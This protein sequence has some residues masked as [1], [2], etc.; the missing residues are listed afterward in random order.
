LIKFSP[1][2]SGQTFTMDEKDLKFVGTYN[3]HFVVRRADIETVTTSVVSAGKSQLRVIGKG[4][5]LATVI[6]PAS[7]AESARNWILD[8]KDGPIPEGSPDAS[9]NVPKW[10]TVPLLILAAMV[11]SCLL[12]VSRI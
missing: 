11:A 12:M 8:H 3:G 1:T 6:L 2:L 4:T 10:V 7:W 9:F 5:D